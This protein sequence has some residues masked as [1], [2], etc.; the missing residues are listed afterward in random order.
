MFP[1][2]QITLNYR[3]KEFAVVE[4]VL[5]HF[6]QYSW[7]ANKKIQDGC[8]NKRPDLFLD[9]GEKII[10]VEIDEKQHMRY[11]SICENKRMMEVSQDVGHR[12]IIVIRFNP[13]DYRNENNKKIPS[14][15]GITR[16]TQL[17]KL[18]HHN[19]WLERLETLKQNIEEKIYASSDKT[20]EITYLFYDKNDICNM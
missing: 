16:N 6:P 17:C 20:L 7:V 10:I 8:S 12:P 3:T 9:M 11:E 1:D 14:C 15:W 4:Y 13:D 18:V 19:D 2:K 5:K